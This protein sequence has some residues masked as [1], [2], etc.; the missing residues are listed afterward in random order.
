MRLQIPRIS[1]QRFLLVLLL[2]FGF[3]AATDVS[4]LPGLAKL[5]KKA[6]EKAT[7]GSDLSQ[8]GPIGDDTVVF[9]DLVVELTGERLE[10]II[11]TFKSAQAAGAGRPPLV[12]KLNRVQDERG[13]HMDKHGDAIQ[14]IREK[15]DAVEVCRHDGLNQMMSQK[16]QEYSQKALTDPT[17][18]EKFTKIA[19]RYNAAAIG[20]DSAATKSAQDAMLAVIMPTHDDTLNVYKQCDPLPPPLPSEVKLDQYDQQ[21]ASLSEQIRKIDEQVAEKQAEQGGMSSEQFGMAA[22]RIQ[23]YLSWRQ[24]ASYSKSATRGFSSEEIEE[25]EKHLAELQAVMG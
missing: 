12:E 8:E 6:K 2:A 7:K 24:S 15:R 5:A 18:R 21:V 4:A 23:M 11:A 17:I 25:L 16:M 22:E 20:G 19:Q 14:K 3:S 10:R 13:K 9:D 1:N